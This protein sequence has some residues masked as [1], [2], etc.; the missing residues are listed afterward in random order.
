MG[1]VA[2][3]SEYIYRTTIPEDVRESIEQEVKKINKNFTVRAVTRI[4]MHP[5]DS[6]IY[7]V[8]V[9]NTAKNTYTYWGSYYHPRKSL[10][11]GRYDIGLNDAM[12]L[13]WS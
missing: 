7:K 5:D 12:S 10:N 13:L 2:N 3:N 4:S 8:V 9:E 1:N 11:Y 6:E